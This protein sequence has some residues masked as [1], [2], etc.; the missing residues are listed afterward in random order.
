[1]SAAEAKRVY[2]AQLGSQSIEKDRQLEMVAKVR[3]S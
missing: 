3:R 1:M 2:S